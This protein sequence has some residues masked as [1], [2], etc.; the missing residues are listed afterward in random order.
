METTALL[1]LALMRFCADSSI[2]RVCGPRVSVS[3]V[4]KIC[5]RVHL[6]PDW[7]IVRRRL[8]AHICQKMKNAA[9]KFTSTPMRESMASL[10]RVIFGG[11]RGS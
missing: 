2:I 6:E 3:H 9:G 1:P 10:D 8:R 7:S 11:L 4:I 5:K